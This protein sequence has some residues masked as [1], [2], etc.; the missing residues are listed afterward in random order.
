MYLRKFPIMY[1]YQE[2]LDTKKALFCII[3]GLLQFKRNQRTI[4]P[5]SLIW[6]LRIC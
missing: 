6:V 4:G 3:K 5:V 1:I 2:I